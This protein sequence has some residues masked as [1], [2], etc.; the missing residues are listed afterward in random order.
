LPDNAAPDFSIHKGNA[1]LPACVFVH[2]LGMSKYIWTDPARARIMGGLYP[3]TRL[4]APQGERRTL[5]HDLRDA[6]YTVAAWSQRRPVGPAHAAVE[7]LEQVMAMASEIAPKGVVLI[8]HSRGGLIARGAGGADAAGLIRGIITICAPHT[9]SGMARWAGLLGPLAARLNRLLPEA[10]PGAIRSAVKR[11]LGFL[12]STG[13][14]ELLPGSAFLHSLP[15]AAPPG[16]YCL[17][18]GGTDPALIRIPGLMPLPEG[19]ERI[20][21]MKVLPEEMLR[22]RGDGLVS[23]RSAVLPCAEEHLDFPA[24]HVT[25]LVDPEARKAVFERVVRNCG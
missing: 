16:A 10:E 9:G 7:E 5:Y 20:L 12:E 4:L 6:G 19:L 23:A 8:G 1:G 18:V 25:V 11:T 13:V 21:S 3:L 14:R 22:G 2:G 15:P 17:S 24:N